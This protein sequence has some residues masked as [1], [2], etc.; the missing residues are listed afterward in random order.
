MTATRRRPSALLLLLALLVAACEGGPTPGPGTLTASVV[1]PNGAEGAA[2]LSLHGP[3]IQ[4]VSG[5]EGRVWGEPH[6]DSVTVVVVA[7]QAG[8]LSFRVAV[9]D[10]L[11]RPEARLVEVAG[12]DDALRDGLEGYRVE[13]IP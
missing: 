5:G 3:G 8:L 12:P 10:T 9:S 13:L 2:V 11:Q 1:S 4:G 6:G 7:D